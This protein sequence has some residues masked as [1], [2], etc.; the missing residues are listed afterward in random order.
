VIT[1]SVLPTDAAIIDM[2]F[3]LLDSAP[4]EVWLVAAEGDGLLISNEEFLA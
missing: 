3:V 1:A 2:V 4:A